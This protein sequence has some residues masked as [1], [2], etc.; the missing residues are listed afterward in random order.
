MRVNSGQEHA[1]PE[2]ANLP[3]I[4]L[5][6]QRG[7]VQVT[8]EQGGPTPEE[9]KRIVEPPLYYVFREFRVGAAAYSPVTGESQPV[10]TEYRRSF[11]YDMHGRMCCMRGFS[12][13]L[14]TR[15]GN[16]GYP[17]AYLDLDPPKDPDVYKE[18]WDRVVSS[19]EFRPRQDE[20]LAA[21]AANDGGLID[22]VPAF[23]KM[24][25]IAMACV[26]YRGA[27]IDVVTKR[28]PIVNSIHQLLTR[29]IPAVGKVC[30]GNSLKGR[31]TVYTLDSLHHSDY[32]ADIVLVDEVHEAV[33]DRYADGL[34]RYHHARI[35][36]LSA[37]L[38]T[39][40]D[41]LQ[42]RLVGLCGPVIFKIDQQEAEQLKLVTPAVVYW[43][44]IKMDRNPADNTT[45]PVFRKQ[46]GIWT[47]T[48]RNQRIAETAMR[49]YN[50]GRQVL[51]SVDTVEHA[52]HLKKLLPD[53]ELC[54]SEQGMADPKKLA[55]FEASGIQLG[56]LP[57]MTAARRE[58]LQ[59]QFESGEL[60]GV[61][62]TSVWR[63]GV[64]F[65]HLRVFIYAGGGRSATDV[66]Q[67]GGRVCRTDDDKAYGIIVDCCDEFDEGFRKAALARRQV[68]ADRGHPQFT[69]D[70]KPWDP[71]RKRKKG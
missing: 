13:L 57:T 7:I 55:R 47:N 65:N 63:V 52:L 2:S 60:Q 9:V 33:T 49:Y 4:V 54:H 22:A 70:G 1:M 28:R 66:T 35:F 68:W 26:L 18:H 10:T 42:H 15:L 69:E 50:E 46:L 71:R 44:S 3:K 38:D 62:A 12:H 21:I 14:M 48:Y 8:D 17:V 61:I 67:G 32:D 40:A 64:S 19:F 39:R 16:A 36:G 59:Q 56:E 11:V 45:N 23:G 37:T 25:V 20:C 41:G 58:E 31:V 30:A 51:V 24:W 5:R 27:K 6:K 43:L 34:G 29:Y 53:F